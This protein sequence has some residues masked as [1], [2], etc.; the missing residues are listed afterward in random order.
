VNVF[1]CLTSH[2]PDIDADVVACW[3]QTLVEALPDFLKQVH[4][5]GYFPIGQLEEALDMTVD[6]GKGMSGR[7]GER[8]IDDKAMFTLLPDAVSRH[9]AERTIT[10]MRVVHSSQ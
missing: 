10:S 9:R 7:Y 4:E 1:D 5:A 2:C 8:I 3:A 6:D